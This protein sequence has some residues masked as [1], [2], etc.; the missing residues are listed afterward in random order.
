MKIVQSPS[1]TRSIKKLHPNQKK[2]LDKSIRVIMAKPE[3]GTPKIGELKGISIYKFQINGLQWLLA[4]RIN[5][6]KKIKLLVVGPYENFYRDLQK[7]TGRHT[8]HAIES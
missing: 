2:S 3:I 6:A 8:R 5:G 4:Y 1:F 7:R